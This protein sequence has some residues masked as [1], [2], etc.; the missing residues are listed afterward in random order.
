M[1][2]VIDAITDRRLFGA[3]AEFR[4][5][6]TWSR[7]LVYVKATCGL[8]LDAAELEV[9][10]QHTG[11]SAPRAGGYPESVAVVGVQSGKSFIAAMIAALSAAVTDLRDVWAILVARMLEPPSGR[12]SATPRGRSR[13]FRRSSAWW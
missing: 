5:L 1:L 3:M 2:T 10:R 8:P 9:F 4:D 7:W 6:A 12:C 13:K 11:R